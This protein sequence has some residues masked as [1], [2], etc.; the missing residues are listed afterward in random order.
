MVLD[1]DFAQAESR[2]DQLSL[3]TDEFIPRIEARISAFFQRCIHTS[4]SP[5]QRSVYEQYERFALRP[6]KRIRPLVMLIACRGFGHPLDEEALALAA[7]IE[8]MHATLLVHDDIIDCADTRRGEPSLHRV[9]AAYPPG[10]GRAAGEHIALIAGDLVVFECLEEALRSPLPRPVLSEYAACYRQTNLG[11]LLDIAHDGAAFRDE[12]IPALVMKYKTAS[13]TTVYPFLMGCALAQPLTEELQSLIFQTFY[14]L[15]ENF[16][17]RDDYLGVFAPP[18]ETG[19]SANDL[20]ASKYTSLVHN[21]WKMSGQRN[22]FRELFMLK[23]KNSDDILLLIQLIRASGA[24]ERLQQMVSDNLSKFRDG[25][26]LLPIAP[27]EKEILVLL[28]EKIS[29]F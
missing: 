1:D 21:A 12:D 19:K 28:G 11:Q 27:R 9:F 23:A 6:G 24:P 22:L 17:L 2:M 29:V 20:S 16:Q 25:A 7:L 14:P 3:F 5:V 18:D 4:V 13:Y 8:I 15:G 26:A 10:P